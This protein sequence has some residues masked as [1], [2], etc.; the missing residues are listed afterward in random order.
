MVDDYVKI[1]MS[2]PDAS[3]GLGGRDGLTHGPVDRAYAK[4]SN[5]LSQYSSL[6]L[7]RIYR[8]FQDLLRFGKSRKIV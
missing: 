6:K 5:D 8:I 2:P 3:E 1:R 7:D 4:V